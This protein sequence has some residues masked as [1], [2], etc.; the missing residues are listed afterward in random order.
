MDTAQISEKIKLIPINYQQEVINAIDSI[1]EKKGKITDN[2]FKKKP[3]GL[4]KGRIKMSA[5]FDQP[6]DDFNSYI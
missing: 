2:P 4:P 3:L 6:L 5:S 1:L